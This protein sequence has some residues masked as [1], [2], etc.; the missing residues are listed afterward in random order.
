MSVLR[1]T[2]LTV[3]YAPGV[4]AVRGAGLTAGAG[5]VLGVVGES[6]SGKTAL[7]L[8]VMGLLPDDAHVTGSVRL[9][10]RELLGRSDAELSRVR[11]KDLAMV[12]QDPLSAL[13]PV[14]T[15]G[16]QIAET[17]RI[18]AR[19]SRAAARARAVALL[20]LVGIPGA[21]RRARAYPHELSGG[22]R[23][24]VM[25]AMAIANDPAR[26]R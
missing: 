18:H 22:M 3:R 10:G 21:G 11:G 12:F 2:D 13:T 7:A 23:Q 19:V 14:R 17:V 20:D 24:R 9:R 15:V 1:V 4:R 8:A 16:D 26:P 25:I 6:G 5:E